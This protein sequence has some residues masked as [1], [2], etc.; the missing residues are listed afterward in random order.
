MERNGTDNENTTIIDDSDSVSKLRLAKLKHPKNVIL[1]YL[2]INSVRNK[3]TDLDV[4]VSNFVDI[5][6]IF[7]TKLDSSFPDAQFKLS[8][9]AK[10]YRLDVSCSSGGLLTYINH[11]IHSRRLLDFNIPLDIQAICVEINLRKKKWLHIAIY[12]PPDQDIVYF[13]SKISNMLDFYANRYQNILLMGDF[14]ELTSS[15]KMANFMMQHDLSSILTK[16]TCF[17][18]S[19]GRAIDLILTNNKSSFQ[20]SGSCE[21]GISDWHHLIYTTLRGSFVKL[22]PKKVNYRCYRKFSESAFSSDL[23]EKLSHM[24][25]DN[26]DSFHTILKNTLDKHAPIKSKLLCGNNQPHVKTDL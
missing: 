24:N 22:P 18:S 19:S 14:N 8:K 6:S 10:P 25:V 16:A 1:S 23:E 4:L 5:L 11:A 12:R 15:T 20:L 17:K 2:N 3:L 9:F 26:F 13:F 7:E 21:T